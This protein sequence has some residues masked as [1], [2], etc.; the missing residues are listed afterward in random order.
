M[1]ADFVG[2]ASRFSFFN[3]AGMQTTG[4]TYTRW[5]ERMAGL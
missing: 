2:I 1:E 5:S 3:L 4:K